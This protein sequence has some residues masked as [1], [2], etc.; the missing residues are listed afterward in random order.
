MEIFLI[1]VWL[2]VFVGFAAWWR[3]HSG[4]GWFIL[5]MIISP[6]VA[7]LF[8]LTRGKGRT[9]C[10]NCHDLVDN[11]EVFCRTCG[12]MMPRDGEMGGPGPGSHY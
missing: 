4:W 1:W 11:E 7:G 12:M 2:S 3:E 5:S 9:T 8:L 6:L 10:P